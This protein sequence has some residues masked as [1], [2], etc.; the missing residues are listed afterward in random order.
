MKGTGL[1][2]GL[3]V[4]VSAGGLPTAQGQDNAVRNYPS[5]PVRIIVGYSAGGGNDIVVRVLAPHLSEGL[6]QSVLV[7]NR[8]GA[9]GIIA[10][11]VVAK[12]PPDGYT[13]LMGPSGPMTMN[14]GLYAKLPYDSLRDF[15]PITMIGSFPLVLVVNPA[16]PVTTVKELIAYAKASPQKANYGASAAPF[17]LAAELFNQKTGTKFQH[18]PYKG[19]GESVNSVVSGEVTMT[20]ADP[21]P[22][23]GPLKGG[24]VRPLAVTSS[25][26]HPAFP[27]LPTL[28]EAG[29][30]IDVMLWMAFLAPAGT[31]PGVVGRLRDEVARVVKLPD[32]RER[33]AALGVDPV[34]NSPQQFRRIMAAD[35]A[36]WT[37]VAKAANIKA[38]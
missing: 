13:I 32:V 20:I 28:A 3:L 26:R 22:V 11:E 8:P 16:L 9:Q 24:R 7:E 25:Q 38:E 21:P 30:D 12:S 19:S 14:P 5:K 18:I 17:Q 10:C 23:V 36:K 33:F 31:P 27:G 35:I 15:A 34:A 37:A 1:L 6:R 29:I 4:A 2:L